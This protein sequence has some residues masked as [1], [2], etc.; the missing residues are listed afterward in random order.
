MYVIL[1]ENVNLISLERSIVI[2][3]DDLDF[4]EIVAHLFFQLSVM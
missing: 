1:D 2:E 3:I 4:Y